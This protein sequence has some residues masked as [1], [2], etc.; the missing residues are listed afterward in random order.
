MYPMI[1]DGFLLEDCWLV[2]CCQNQ[3]EINT[4]Y[5]VTFERVTKETLFQ[6]MDG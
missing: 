6:E 3:I 1:S 4:K 2:G 5:L